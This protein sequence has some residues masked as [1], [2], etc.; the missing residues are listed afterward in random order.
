MLSYEAVM[1]NTLSVK[2]AL[3]GSIRKKAHNDMWEKRYKAL[4]KD[5]KKDLSTVKDMKVLNDKITALQKVLD[6]ASKEKVIHTNKA[7]RL[8]SIYARKVTALS[9]RGSSKKSAK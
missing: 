2:K 7:N 3:R 1:P 8:K 9:Q 5:I 4:I 6:K